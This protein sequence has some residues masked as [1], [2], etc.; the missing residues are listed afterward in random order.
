MRYQPGM[1][2]KK[3][4]GKKTDATPLRKILLDLDGI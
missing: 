4:T 3:A 1:A 2:R